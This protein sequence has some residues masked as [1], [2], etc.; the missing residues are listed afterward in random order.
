MNLGPGFDVFGLGL[1]AFEDKVRITTRLEQSEQITIRISGEGV[2]S[3][4]SKVEDNC[5]GV[6][7]KKMSQ[8]FSIKNN[9]DI[10]LEKKVPAGMGIGSSAALAVA[11]AV[12]FDSLFEL[13]IEK[14]RLVEYCTQGEIVSAGT[15]HYDNV[16]GS[17]LGGFVIVRTSPRLEFIRLAA[18]KISS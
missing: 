15:K 17:L 14:T 7:V 6:V 13:K 11:A 3:V 10:N 2:K 1:D 18:L 12:A 4:P 8:D 9:L 5:A 16:S